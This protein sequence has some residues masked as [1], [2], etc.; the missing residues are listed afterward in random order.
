MTGGINHSPLDHA[1]DKVLVD[2]RNMPSG[3]RPSSSNSDL[4]RVVS[5]I[6]PHSKVQRG[7]PLPSEPHMSP[8]VLSRFNMLC[9]YSTALE[10]CSLVRRIHEI[11][12]I[13]GMEYGFWRRAA[14]Y[15]DIARSKSPISSVKLPAVTRR[16][17]WCASGKNASQRPK[18]EPI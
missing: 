5:D 1:N 9:K 2:K 17:Q 16:C 6:Q 14:S 4:V 18:Y 15:A 3:G 8:L 11:E 13:A 10:N 7:N 12:F